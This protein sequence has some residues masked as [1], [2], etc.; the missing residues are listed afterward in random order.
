M[1]GGAVTDAFMAGFTTALLG[2]CA[3][4]VAA[5]AAGAA[6]GIAKREWRR[7][8]GAK[9]RAAAAVMVL[10]AGGAAYWCGATKGTVSVTDPYIM[11]AGSYLTN[12]VAHIAI[13]KRT[14]LLPDTTEILV[15]AREVSSTNAADWTRLAPHLTYAEHP[16]DYAL[17]NAT[18]HNVIVAADFTPEPTVHTNGVWQMKGF[19]IPGTGRAAFPNT[20]IRRVE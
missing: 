12:D 4:C 2:G 5:L 8:K 15:Y 10:V 1:G 3:V 7:W 20:K 18:N 11:D 14:P 9:D 13:A 6:I 16:Y 17:A 19:E